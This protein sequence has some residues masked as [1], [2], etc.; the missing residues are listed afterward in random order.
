MNVN[1]HIPQQPETGIRAIFQTHGIPQF[2]NETILPKGLT[3]IIFDLSEAPASMAT[4]GETLHTR[5]PKCFIV[6]FSKVPIHIQLPKQQTYFGLYLDPLVIQ[7]LLGVPSGEF[8]N[9]LV[10]LTLVDASFHELWEQLAERQDFS[11]RVA[12]ATQWLRQRTKARHTQEGMLNTF[13]CAPLTKPMSVP[14]VA[15]ALCYSPRHL[16]RKLKALTGMNTEEVL[17]FKKYLRALNLI[18]HSTLPLTAIS[19]ESHFT[20][21]S[22]FIK[23]FRL[24]TNMTPGEYSSAKWQVPQAGHLFYNVR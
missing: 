10:D 4:M 11:A 9:K 22:H 8:A 7:D 15:D 12:L 18:H 19:H 14:D 20:D 3:E 2:S 24:F 17:L 1:F 16:S 13:I 6:S 21:Q 5:L 23:A